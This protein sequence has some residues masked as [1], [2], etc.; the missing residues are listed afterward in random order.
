MKRKANVIFIALLLLVVTSL[1]G[2]TKRQ[3]FRV[4]NPKGHYPIIIHSVAAKLVAINGQSSIKKNP[5]ISFNPT[6][7]SFSFDKDPLMAG[8]SLAFKDRTNKTID[9]V[10]VSLRKKTI[11]RVIKT[12]VVIRCYY[13]NKSE[14]IVRIDQ[15]IV[16]GVYKRK[17]KNN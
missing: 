11:F 6:R 7:G 8:V 2:Q 4:D 5:E 16:Y 14:D 10:T 17:P 13:S 3:E 15:G 9:S 12:E 1:S